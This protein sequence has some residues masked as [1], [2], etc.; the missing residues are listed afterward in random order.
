MKKRSR[1]DQSPQQPDLFFY[2]SLLIT[3]P[4]AMFTR[5]GGVSVSPFTSLNLSY[6]V[7]D[8][9]AAVREN[10]D[11]VKK[12]LKV[13]Y[14]ASTVQVHGDQVLIVEGLDSD[15]EYQGT[16]A[17]V[18]RQKGVGLL[19]QQADCQAVLLYDP[20]RQVIA[21]V[22][23]GWRG[24]VA[25]II[26]KTVK[27]MEENFGTSPEDLRA[28]ISPSLGPCCA[29]FIHYEQELP[30]SFQQWRVA[31]NYFNFWKISRWQLVEAGL[32]EAHIRATEICT[33]CNKDFFSFRRATKKQGKPGRTGRNGSI[34]KLLS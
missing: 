14:L 26:A 3:T 11:K 13:Q 22:H 1:P 15:H 23:N 12:E 4:H 6:G 17:L 24:S 29:E 30:P 32:L 16:D 27:T 25:N 2:S 7:G 8:E 34:I 21:A 19:I 9:P 18:T 28:V 33:M 20:L 31:D 10:R 5:Q